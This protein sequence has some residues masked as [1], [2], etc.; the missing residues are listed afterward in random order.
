MDIQS[1]FYFTEVAKDLHITRTANRLFISQQTL[2]NHIL[3]LEEYYG[4]KL[5]NRKPTLSLTYAGEFVL[6]FAEKL[7]R[8]DA[9]L[10]DLLADIQKQNRGLILFGASTLRMNACLPEILPE[11]SA[12]Y[13]GIELRI[14]DANS[15]R[16]EQLILNGELDLAIVL[17]NSENPAIESTYLMSDQVYLCVTDALLTQHY[18]DSATQIKERSLNGANIRDFTRL[19]FCMLNNRL[20]KTI[21]QCFDEEEITPN[22]YTTSEYMKISTSISFKGLA[23]CFTTRIGLL[24]QKGDIPDDLNIFPLYFKG[25][26]LFQPISMIHHK[27]R[28]LSSY[29]K[30]FFNLILKYFHKVELMPIGQL[31]EK[32]IDL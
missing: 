9:N 7:N 24:N 2:S 22:I 1:L 28:Y 8:E 4:V 23:A 32:R 30:E 21:Q 10:R 16:L 6:N 14:T 31:N 27:E 20:G 18:G 26:P 19:P 29:K 13:P 17:A 15:G 12:G 25:K 3:R 5:L 11:F